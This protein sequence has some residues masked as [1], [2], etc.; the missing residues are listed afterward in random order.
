MTS[1]DVNHNS[2]MNPHRKLHSVSPFS[3]DNTFNTRNNRPIIYGPEKKLCTKYRWLVFLVLSLVVVVFVMT[4][5]FLWQVHLRH[6]SEAA[7]SI[8]QSQKP[9]QRLPKPIPLPDL[10]QFLSSKLKEMEEFITKKKF[11]ALSA[12]VVYRDNIIWS[13]AFGVISR[14]EKP[15]RKPK[16]SS[17]YPCASISKVLTALIVYK[18]FDESKIT[19][20]DDPVVKFDADFKIKNPFDQKH[21]ITLRNLLDMSSGIP[22]EAPCYPSTKNNLCPYNHSVMIKRIQNSS[23]LVEPNTI[24]QYSNFGYALLGNVLAKAFSGGD[25]NALVKKYVLVPLG[26]KNT[27]LAL[28]S[29]QLNDVP[30][31]Y[32][33]GKLSSVVNWGWLDPA[34]GF[35]TTVEDLSKMVIHLMSDSNKDRYLSKYTTRLLFSIAN[36]MTDGV[37]ITGTPW[38]MSPIDG[39]VHRTKGGSIYGYRALVAMVPELRIAMNVLCSNCEEFIYSLVQT[40]FDAKIVPVLRQ[41]LS[42][43]QQMKIVLPPNY[44]AY[45]GTYVTNDIPDLRSFVI[46]KEDKKLSAYVNKVP[47]FYLNYTAPRTFKVVINT[48][49]MSCLNEY[50][51][52]N[53]NE[54]LVFDEI[55]SRDDLSHGFIAS[56]ASPSGKAYLYRAPSK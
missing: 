35:F 17:I 6:K 11:G 10:R 23:L 9:C 8:K 49:Q 20:L 56:G 43:L 47:Y 18:L 42:K 14:S 44:S 52:A 13:G 27:M 25:Y 26:M 53:V 28:N 54:V 32:I 22:R 15:S 2:P 37:T 33:D 39:I 7:Q 29:K 45:V 55:S 34:A 48:D 38:E 50:V 1:N 40:Y 4:G 36:V 51:I 3:H 16:T 31:A 46:V 21:N 5:L 24:L 30:R 41:H 12:N 19:S